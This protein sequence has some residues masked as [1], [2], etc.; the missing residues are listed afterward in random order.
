MLVVV[1]HR[2]IERAF[3]TFLDVE[4]LRGLDVLEVDAA[5]SGGDALYGLTELLRVFLVDLDVKDVDATINLEEQTFTLHHGFAAHGT[6]VAQSQDGG[7]VG[8]NG[9]EIAFI[10]VFIS[11]VGILLDF[12]TGVSNTWRV[13]QRKVGLSTISLGGLYFDFART[14][15]LMILKSSFFGDFYHKL[16]ISEFVFCLIIPFVCLCAPQN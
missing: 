16:F 13:G 10:R 6:N 7:A 3:Q 9:H 12:Q 14:A 5:K 2:D 8:D 11:V 1:H 15:C 4:A